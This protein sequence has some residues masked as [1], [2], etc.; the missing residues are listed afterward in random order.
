MH[1][2]AMRTLALRSP[3][4]ASLVTL[5]LAG[6]A[7]AQTPAPGADTLAP[8]PVPARRPSNF[9]ELDPLGVLGFLRLNVASFE[10]HYERIIAGHHGV[11]IAGDF[12]HVH[13][14]A[15][16]LQSHQWTFGGS[17][18]YRYYF[19]ESQGPF[20]GL[21]VGYRAGYGH[22]EE[23]GRVTHVALLNEQFRVMAQAGYRFVVPATATPAFTVVPRVAVGYGPYTVRENTDPGHAHGT[24]DPTAPHDTPEAVEH[25]ERTSQDVLGTGP[26]VVD[27]E[28]S[29]GVA[30]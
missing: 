28:L 10:A 14:A 21:Q 8:A 2:R 18:T 25:A 16:H 12:V 17:L 11:Q 22:F 1:R 13:H 27:L 6:A 4:L 29:F 7:H 24:T 9:V 20:A 23:P 5:A 30:F 19:F 3:A 26:V 15:R